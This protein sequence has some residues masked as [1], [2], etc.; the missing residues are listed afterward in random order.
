MDSTSFNPDQVSQLAPAVF[1][2]GPSALLVV[3]GLLFTRIAGRQLRDNAADKES[4]RVFRGIVVAVWACAF[5]LIGFSVMQWWFPRHAESTLRG[6]LK[7]LQG[8]EDVVGTSV[9]PHRRLF[10]CKTYRKDGLFEIDWRVV[11]DTRLV[12][13][14][15][16]SHRRRARSVVRWW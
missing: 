13:G 12:D 16:A 4:R 2:Y 3:V 15:F 7:T 9:D 10:V 11:S 14:T 6:T 5:V 1:Q 8:S